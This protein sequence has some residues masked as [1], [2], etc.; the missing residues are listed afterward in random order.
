MKNLQT[1]IEKKLNK[2]VELFKATDCVNLLFEAKIDGVAVARVYKSF[3]S[4]LN[5]IHQIRYTNAD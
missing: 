5:P 1:I 2:K 3:D 4:Q